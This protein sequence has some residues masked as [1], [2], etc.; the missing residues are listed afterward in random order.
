MNKKVIVYNLILSILL[1]LFKSDLLWASEVSD[2]QYEEISY[3][4]LI[5]ELNSRVRAKNRV[6]DTE[7]STDPFERVTI[8]TSFGLINSIHYL[9]VGDRN[10]SRFEDGIGLGF[11]IDLFNP[12]WLAEAQLKNYGRST[13]NEQTFSLR[14]FEL[15]LSYRESSNTKTS[16][17]I[18]QGLGAKYIKYTAPYLDN[19]IRESTPV[20]VIGSSLNTKFTQNF[21]LGVELTGSIALVSETIDRNSINLNFKFDNY[22]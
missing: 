21:S 2:A 18:I 11:G 19:S 17:K 8:H 1:I 5:D 20:Y 7:V 9:T 12:E 14:E 6:E 4:E 16:F 10:I 15:R 22:F 13:R 3:N